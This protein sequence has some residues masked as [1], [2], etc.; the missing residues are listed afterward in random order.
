M[1]KKFTRREMLTLSSKGISFG[2]GAF[3][4]AEKSDRYSVLTLA[5]LNLIR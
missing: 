4:I 5:G 2:A 1:K 3:F